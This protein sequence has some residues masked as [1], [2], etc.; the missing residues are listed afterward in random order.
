M[1]L[2]CLCV[3]LHCCSAA[4]ADSWSPSR[5]EFDVIVSMS[6]HVAVGDLRTTDAACAHACPLSPPLSLDHDGLGRYG[7]PLCPDGDLLSMDALRDVL[8]RPQQLP[9]CVHAEE[10]CSSSAAAVSCVGCTAVV[11]FVAFSVV[12]NA[13]GLEPASPRCRLVLHWPAAL[14]DPG[15]PRGDGGAQVKRA[16]ADG[17]SW[18]LS[19][20]C[21]GFSRRM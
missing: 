13:T 5:G 12:G 3:S 8:L 10:G 20:I 19:R 7:D 21:G 16:T 4:L 2:P 14:G 15:C 6:R 11:G 18:G 9:A 1:H 17:A